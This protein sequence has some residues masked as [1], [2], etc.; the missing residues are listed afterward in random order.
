MGDEWTATNVP[1][2]LRSA[3]AMSRNLGRGCAP[4][5]PS[6]SIRPWTLYFLHMRNF[7]QLVVATA[8]AVR[9]L[10]TTAE[11]AVTVF[12]AL[13]NWLVVVGVTCIDCRDI[14]DAHGDREVVTMLLLC[15]ARQSRPCLCISILREYDCYFEAWMF[16]GFCTKLFG[17]RVNIDPCCHLI[18]ITLWSICNKFHNSTSQINYHMSW[19]RWQQGFKQRGNLDGKTT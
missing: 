18:Q 8:T 3:K 15:T 19:I 13:V 17:L 16:K 11:A 4:P 10:V 5:V 7:L 12:L 6:P 9:I 14:S 2:R 1:D